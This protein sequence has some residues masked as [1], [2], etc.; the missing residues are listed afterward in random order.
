M[1]PSSVISSSIAIASEVLDRLGHGDYYGPFKR[2]D[3]VR[4]EVLALSEILRTM[5]KHQFE[6]PSEK[7]WRVYTHLFKSCGEILQETRSEVE[8]IMELRNS[9][10]K[11][12]I[13]MLTASERLNSLLRQL[14]RQKSTFTVILSGL[15]R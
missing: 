9:R 2:L 15:V 11:Q 8:K 5:S 6:H 7:S 12:L 14:D 3:S 10:A 13:Y 1:D 4:I